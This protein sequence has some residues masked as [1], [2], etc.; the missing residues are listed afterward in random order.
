MVPWLLLRVLAVSN[1][2]HRFAMLAAW[3]GCWHVAYAALPVS[4]RRGRP[5][6]G[7]VVSVCRPAILGSW[8]FVTYGFRQMCGYTGR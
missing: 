2:K 4:S 5:A 3:R 6:S 1:K 8:S 7:Y